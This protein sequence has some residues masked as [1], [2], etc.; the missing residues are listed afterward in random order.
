MKRI[1]I[2]EAQ[3]KHAL[4][5]KETINQVINK[6]PGES[7]ESA[8]KTADREASQEAP[9]A[10]INYVI[11]KEELTEDAVENSDCSIDNIV[12]YI[13][14]NYDEIDEFTTISEINNMIQDAYI[15]VCG[16]EM[17]YTNKQLFR[18]IRNSLLSKINE[19]IK[20]TMVFTKKQIKEAK[21]NKRMSE[22]RVLTKADILKNL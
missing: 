21:R 17:D 14:T 10:D 22:G 13:L 3:L 1:Y 2:T 19:P 5:I 20:E 4:T 8:V 15:Q 7:L 6:K 12:N 11:P 9:N 18:D 16:C